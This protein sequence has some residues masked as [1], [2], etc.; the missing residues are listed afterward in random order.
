[1]RYRSKRR[2]TTNRGAKYRGAPGV[3]VVRGKNLNLP[4]DDPSGVACATPGCGAYVKA[5]A[6]G[7]PR[8]HSEGGY[9][10]NTRAGFYKCPGSGTLLD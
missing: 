8:A 7:R 6:S 3:P 5:L 1:M 2:S 10:T 4:L 9:M